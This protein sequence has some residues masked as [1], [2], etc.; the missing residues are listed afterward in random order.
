MESPGDH[1][2][3]STILCK[4]PFSKVESPISDRISELNWVG[5]SK[6]TLQ[7]ESYTPLT[8]AR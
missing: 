2:Q 8:K 6:E 7:H 1:F 3:I 5:L 4:N